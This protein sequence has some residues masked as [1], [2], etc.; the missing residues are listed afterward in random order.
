[1]H[2]SGDGSFSIRDQRWKLVFCGGS[3]GWS[4]PELPKDAAYLATQPPMQLYDMQNDISETK[5]VVEQHPDIVKK[6]TT[7]MK[8]YILNGRSTPGAKQSNDGPNTWKQTK[9]FLEN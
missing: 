8:E 2:H 1:M 7:V 6:L 4:F 5:N 9:L 3:G